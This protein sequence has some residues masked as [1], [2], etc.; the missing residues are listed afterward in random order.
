MSEDIYLEPR[1]LLYGGDADEAVAAG[2]AGRL[3]GGTV[4]FT[5]VRLRG[6]G[7]NDAG[8]RPYRDLSVSSERALR[9]VLETIEAARPAGF[10]APKGQAAVMGVV[11]VT[12]DSFSDGGEFA[13]TSVAIGHGRSLAEEGARIL[14]IGGESTRPGSDAMSVQDELAR[15]IPVIEGLRDTGLPISI[16][17]RKADVMERAAGAGASVI[18]D[19]SALQFDPQALVMAARL[20][21]PVVLMHSRGDPKT[22]QDDPQYDDVLLDVFDH[23][24]ERIGACVEAGIPKERIIADPGIGFGKTF[25]HNHALL[26]GL[27]LF[28]GLG[29]RILLG[30][31]RKAFLGRLTGEPVAGK[32]VIGSVT[33][34]LAGVMQGVQIVRVHD[35][36][37]TVQAL[38]TWDGV[39]GVELDEPV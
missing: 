14:D 11:N 16:D 12:P 33:A 38:R 21:L 39:W 6:R 19:I 9:Q 17:T 23:L 1:A 3:A 8:A 15:V 5:Q 2:T 32:R 7:R 27:S 10:G 4:A 20:E 30:V 36:R 26:R 28:H 13:D 37:A 31:S 18:N 24:E 34:A 35:V 25:E 22:M 29:V